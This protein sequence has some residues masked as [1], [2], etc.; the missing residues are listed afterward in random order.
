MRR[1]ENEKLYKIVLTGLMAALCYV[2]F[3]FL[4][5]PIP[6]MGGDFVAL[7]VGNAFCVLAALLLGGVYGGLAGSLG[8]TVADLMDPAYVTS[9][10]KTFI[11][12]FCI[13]LIA[14]FVAHRI[15][16]ITEDHDGKYV[17][18]WTVIA[19]AV[20]L[21][22]NVIADPVVGYFYKNLIL[23]IPEPAAKI[24]TTWAAGVTLLNAVAGTAVVAAVYMALRPILRKTGIFFHIS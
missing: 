5:I 15:A 23:G 19:S 7:H 21:G 12:K 10:P 9:A 4:K 24:M 16:R 18:K 22:F 2:C 11:L 8:M 6:T 1:Q 13:G 17:F 14:G 3:T 20:S